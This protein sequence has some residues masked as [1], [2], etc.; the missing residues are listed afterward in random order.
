M[1]TDL[2]LFK[3]EQPGEQLGKLSIDDNPVHVGNDEFME[4]VVCPKTIF[5]ICVP[6]ATARRKW[7]GISLFRKVC[8]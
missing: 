5:S 1:I 8:L 3:R 7:T 6:L 2:G 4:I